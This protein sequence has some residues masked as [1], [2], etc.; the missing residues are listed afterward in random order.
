MP[1]AAPDA[2]RQEWA[3]VDRPRRPGPGRHVRRSRL[4]PWVLA[5][6]VSLVVF[7]V[8]AV[9][10]NIVIGPGWPT[11]ASASGPIVAERAGADAPSRDF[12]RPSAAPPALG[13]L[14]VPAPPATQA[15]ST[16]PH[17]KPVAG[18]NQSETDNAVAIVE[19]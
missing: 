11:A 13:I 18:L 19:T 7:G 9:A 10:I 4:V 5:T 6:V 1:D 12:N 8:G 15:P 17:H 14:A 2:Q 3:A 16:P